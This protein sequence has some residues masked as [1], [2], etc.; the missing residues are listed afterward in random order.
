MIANMKPVDRELEFWSN[1]LDS[2]DLGALGVVLE[3]V[4]VDTWEIF[5]VQGHG[6]AHTLIFPS[7]GVEARNVQPP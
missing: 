4:Q 6:V 5:A 1:L 7:E 3:D 2:K